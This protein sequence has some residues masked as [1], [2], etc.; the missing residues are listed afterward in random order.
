MVGRANA[1][2]RGQP[3]RSPFTVVSA[4]WP[5][6][7]AARCAVRWFGW[8]ED[9]AREGWT[10]R[11]RLR[12]GRAHSERRAAP[13]ATRLRATRPSHR[14][15]LVVRRSQLQPA[16]SRLFIALALLAVVAIAGVDARRHHAPPKPSQSQRLSGGRR[17]TGSGAERC[18]EWGGAAAFAQLTTRAPMPSCV[19]AHPASASQRE[20]DQLALALDE[21]AGRL[22]ILGQDSRRPQGQK[23]HTPKPQGLRIWCVH[24]DHGWERW[25]CGEC[26]HWLP[27]PRV[28]D[29]SSLS[30]RLSVPCLC[31]GRRLLDLIFVSL[32]CRC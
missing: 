1:G 2:S 19:A 5:A 18:A 8:K 27:Q 26:A 31:A 28:V 10:T 6:T 12:S 21:R 29:L 16:M 22:A 25:W 23:L 20:P 30:V 15:V 9:E 7:P 14:S 11:V 17:A 4:M 3:A 32:L 24:G 13:V